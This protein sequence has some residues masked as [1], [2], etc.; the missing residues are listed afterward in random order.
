MEKEDLE[1][2]LDLCKENN[3]IL[4]GIQRSARV[5]TFFRVVYWMLIIGSLVGSYYYIQPYI[6]Q[7]LRIY[8]QVGATVNDIKGTTGKVPDLSNFNLPPEILKQLDSLFK[9]K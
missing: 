4:R 9:S 7:L 2:L 5:G 8:N 3:K 6:D 1:Q